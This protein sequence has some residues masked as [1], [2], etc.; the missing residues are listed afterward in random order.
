[1]KALEEALAAAEQNTMAVHANLNRLIELQPYEQV[2][3]PFSG[4]VTLRNLDV[5]ALIGSN[6]TLLFRIGHI[7]RLRIYIY[8][9][10]ANAPGVQI[11]QRASLRV[12]E[13]P[14]R[15]FAGA[16]TRTSDSLDPTSRTLLTEVQAPNPD[17]AL[18]P[19]MHAGVKL[20]THRAQPP[21]LVPGAMIVLPDKTEVATLQEGD[22][23]NQ[24]FQV[25]MAPVTL[26][27]DYGDVIEILSGLNGERVVSNPNDDVQQGARLKGKQSHRF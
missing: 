2:R 5:G 15:E 3:A 11:G 13:Y 6:S 16:I 19:G 26:G 9:P 27:R 21:V 10:E 18:L 24:I 4:V 25:R 14:R 1:V 17:G 23:K 12:M 20:N 22:S 8:V 7:E